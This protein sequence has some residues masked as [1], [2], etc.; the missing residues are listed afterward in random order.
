MPT[1][2]RLFAAHQRAASPSSASPVA[3][4]SPHVTYV[5]VMPYV[6]PPSF[7]PHSTTGTH[8]QPTLYPMPVPSAFGHPPLPHAPAQGQRH[9][10]S[11]SSNSHSAT[12]PSKQRRERTAD[13]NDEFSRVAFPEN[14]NVFVGNL[15]FATTANELREAFEAFGRRHLSDSEGDR[16]SGTYVATATVTRDR[17]GAMMYFVLTV[18]CLRVSRSI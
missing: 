10:P 11:S 8:T 18:E 15:R 1:F 6:V 17:K 13:A 12:R 7:Y 9:I 4:G 5:P 2:L 3:I 14:A 16:R